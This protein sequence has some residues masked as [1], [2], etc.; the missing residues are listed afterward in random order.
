MRPRPRVRS[1]VLTS[2]RQTYPCRSSTPG[3]SRRRPPSK[4]GREPA[5]AQ[6]ERAHRI[7]SELG[8]DP[9]VQD[10]LVRA[11][12][13]AGHRCSRESRKASHAQPLRAGGGSTGRGVG[14]AT[15]P[16]RTL[17]RFGGQTGGL[18]GL[19]ALAGSTQLRSVLPVRPGLPSAE[20]QGVHALPAVQRRRSQCVSTSSA[21]ST[22]SGKPRAYPH[23]WSGRSCYHS[24][25]TA[26]RHKAPRPQE[27]DRE[28]QI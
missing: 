16:E 5:V 9:F 15:E 1:H 20:H 23:T 25:A 24:T 10:L 19:P 2:S 13:A 17:S 27:N 22:L 21:A 12:G 18:G 3:E 6:L 8:A 14:P 26:P 11:R 7:F 4:R 28:P